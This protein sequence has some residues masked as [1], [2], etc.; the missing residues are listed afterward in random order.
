MQ[1]LSVQN[2]P[3][4]RYH[5]VSLLIRQSFNYLLP[6]VLYLP[7]DSFANL[8]RDIIIVKTIKMKFVG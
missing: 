8:I 7:H 4:I 1:R 3:G 2:N 6:I 5:Y